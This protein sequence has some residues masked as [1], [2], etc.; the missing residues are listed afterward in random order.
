[1]WKLVLEKVRVL[2]GILMEFIFLLFF[3]GI[4]WKCRE[5]KLFCD[6]NCYFYKRIVLDILK[7]EVLR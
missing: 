4:F 3:V 5:K 1:M 2:S 6:N 7:C